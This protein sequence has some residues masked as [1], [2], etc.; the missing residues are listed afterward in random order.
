MCLRWYIAGFLCCILQMSTLVGTNSTQSRSPLRL[1]DDVDLRQL[2]TLACHAENQETYERLNGTLHCNA[3]WDTVTCWPPAPAGTLVHMPCPGQLR[4]IKYDT[5]KN[6][7]KMCYENGTWA[8]RADYNGNCRPLVDSFTA[9]SEEMRH[10]RRHLENAKLLNNIG[11]AVSLFCLVIAFTLF[12][13]LKSIRCTRNNIHCN[14]VATFILRNIC[15]FIM[16]EVMNVQTVLDNS[17]YCRVAVTLFN[18]F[19]VTNFFWMFVEG[20]YLHIMVAHAFGTERIKCWM[21]AVIGWCLPIPI[22]LSWVIVMSLLQDERCWVDST[23]GQNSHY[24]FIYHGPVIIVLLVNFVILG[25]I[26][27]I[28]VL[29]LRAHPNSLDTTHYSIKAVKA[30]VVLLPLLGI[31]YML[32]FI[33]PSGRGTSKI[34]FRY[35]NSFLQSFQGCFVS[36]IYCFS[37][38]EVQNAI[39]R[40]VDRWRN[41]QQCAHNSTPSKQMVLAVFSASASTVDKNENTKAASV[42]KGTDLKRPSVIEEE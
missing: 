35:F 16:Q 5:S 28:L 10:W 6:A 34:F 9:E 14:L 17:W 3:T 20:L 7:T 18:Y 4:G 2:L 15:W 30:T 8:V 1:P 38:T 13:Y 21:Y 42:C 22:I 36:V 29:K 41:Q 39:Q 40:R 26:V 37:N 31:T 25:K 32:F 24:D 11:H 27:R 33:H 23:T 19:Q 12:A